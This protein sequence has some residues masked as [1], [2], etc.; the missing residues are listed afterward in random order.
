MAAGTIP[1]TEKRPGARE[2]SNVDQIQL[3]L[4]HVSRAYRRQGIAARLMDEVVTLARERGA[5]YLYISATESRSAVGFYLS[6]GC[7]LAQDVD[8]EL[9]ALEPNDIH[10]VKRLSFGQ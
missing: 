2:G 8:P 6:Q 10:F 7:E 1:I 5:A 9:Y 4:L 3:V